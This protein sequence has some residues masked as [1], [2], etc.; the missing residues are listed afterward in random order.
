MSKERNYKVKVRISIL[1]TTVQFEEKRFLEAARKVIQ[2]TVSQA[3]AKLE[4]D[5][6]I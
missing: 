1:T 3:G 6:Y 5:N 2:A 4:S